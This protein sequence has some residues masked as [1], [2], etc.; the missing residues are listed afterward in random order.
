LLLL[1]CLSA[2]LSF[3]KQA[4]AQCA[5][6]DV[7]HHDQKITEAPSGVFPPTLIESAAG[8]RVWKSIQIGTFANRGALH[9]ALEDAGCQIGDTAEQIFVAP[10][11][12]TGSTSMKLDLFAASVAELG[13]AR[14]N[15]A[16]EDVLARA[17]RLGFGLCAAEVGPQLRL[18]YFDQPVGEF[19]EVA[20]APITTRDGASS[21]FVVA[22]GGAGLLLLGEEINANTRFFPSSR[23]V[24]TRP[25]DV[26][27]AR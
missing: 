14:E 16:R 27:K 13:I 11:F 9:G 21:I 12:A 4:V 5:A 23:F 3:E 26:A 7:L 22:N 24:F 25:V 18:Q 15:V 2:T 6:R 17:Q 20:M 19:L 1:L 8:A 10:K